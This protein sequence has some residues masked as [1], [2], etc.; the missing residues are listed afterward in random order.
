M[1]FVNNN[2]DKKVI[3]NENIYIIDV[4][5]FIIFR[6]FNFKIK[7]IKESIFY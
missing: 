2:D 7:I 1:V 6:Y 4:Y 3:W 5:I